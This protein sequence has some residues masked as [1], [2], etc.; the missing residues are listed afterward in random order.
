VT[1]RRVQGVAALA[2]AAYGI[3]IHALP[4]IVANVIVA[5]AAVWSSFSG[6]AQPASRKV[7]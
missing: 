5:T 4:V 7:E 6:L 2:W 1:L 3:A